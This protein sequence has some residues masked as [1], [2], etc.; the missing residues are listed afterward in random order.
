M[1][2]SLLDPPG[3]PQYLMGLNTTGADGTYSNPG[4]PDADG[5]VVDLINVGLSALGMKAAQ[6]DMG[7]VEG[8]LFV[9]DEVSPFGFT[10]TSSLTLPTMNAQPAHDPVLYPD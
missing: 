9:S 5:A 1:S 8:G 2:L 10:F 6:G 4:C 3:V 7:T